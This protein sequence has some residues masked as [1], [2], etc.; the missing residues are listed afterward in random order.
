[1]KQNDRKRTRVSVHFEIGVLL[2]KETLPIPTEIANVSM[3][4]VLCITQP[5]FHKDAPCKVVLSLS[6]KSQMIINSNILRVGKQ[7]TAISFTSMDEES[8]SL[9]RKVVQ[10]NA[11]DPDLI[12]QELSTNAFDGLQN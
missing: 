2:E 1:M 10:Y 8:F 4:G 11:S 7:E 9:L 5:Q 3:T 6:D 12:E